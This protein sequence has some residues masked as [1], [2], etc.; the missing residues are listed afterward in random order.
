MPYVR[1]A[2]I[3]AVSLLSCPTYAHDA[4][5]TAESDFYSQSPPDYAAIERQQ[6]SNLQS[7]QQGAPPAPTEPRRRR[8]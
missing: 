1:R 5:D 6:R 2:L 3:L 4:G 8:R 7:E